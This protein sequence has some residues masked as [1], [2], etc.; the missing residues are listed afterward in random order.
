MT[1]TKFEEYLGNKV[2]LVI[3]NLEI[4]NLHDIACMILHIDIIECGVE[5]Q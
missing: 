1:T 5:T 2:F 4:T 3:Q